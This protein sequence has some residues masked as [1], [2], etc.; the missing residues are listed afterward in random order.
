MSPTP[1]DQSIDLLRLPDA[2]YFRLEPGALSALK[3]RLARIVQPPALSVPPGSM[4][5]S[6]PEL[7]AIGLPRQVDLGVSRKLPLLLAEVRTGQRMWAVEPQLNRVV[8]VTQLSTG[9]VAA[10]SARSKGRR[11]PVLD[12]SG[13][14]TP[15]DEFNRQLSNIDV[16]LHDLLLW[17]PPERLLGRLA[18]TLL[19]FDLPSNT[20]E[21]EATGPTA[22]TDPM[23]VTAAA[24]MRYGIA[25]EMMDAAKVPPGVHLEAQPMEGDRRH[26]LLCGSIALSATEI[27]FRGDGSLAA[28]MIFVRLDGEAPIV[29]D[30]ILPHRSDSS[31][32]SVRKSFRLDVNDAMQDEARAGQWAAYLVV[33]RFVSRSVTWRF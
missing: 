17:L 12:P 1:Y 5:E 26:L 13:T 22:A 8:V 10:K 2:D 16:T 4:P 14:G 19:D 15:P 20:V 25:V 11:M 3:T 30:L 24:G 32:G 31:D 18:V 28:A 23:S 29:I 9:T 27:S 33:G 7:R 6:I 21:L